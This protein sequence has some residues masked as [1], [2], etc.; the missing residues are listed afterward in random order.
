MLGQRNGEYGRVID[1]LT[2]LAFVPHDADH[3]VGDPGFLRGLTRSSPCIDGPVF[4]AH[5]SRRSV[6]TQMGFL[7]GVLAGNDFVRFAVLAVEMKDELK[8]RRQPS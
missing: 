7:T 3:T 4:R 6:S 8:T 1:V 5:G 2:D